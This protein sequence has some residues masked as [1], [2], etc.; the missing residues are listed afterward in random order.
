MQLA[1]LIVQIGQHGFGFVD[2]GVQG[3]N[4]LLQGLAQF[5]GALVQ[6]GFG[7]LPGFQQHRCVPQGRLGGGKGAFITL[8]TIQ[9][10]ALAGG[11][12]QLGL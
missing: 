9:G 6:A 12:V 1:A 2:L 10:C 5:L 4:R 7:F 8:V 3:G 11:S